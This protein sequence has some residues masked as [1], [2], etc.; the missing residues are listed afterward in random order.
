MR[1]KNMLPL[2][3][4]SFLF[5]AKADVVIRYRVESSKMDRRLQVQKDS[6][7]VIERHDT[8]TPQDNF[9]VVWDL[10]REKAYLASFATK[11]AI[12]LTVPTPSWE[13][14]RL[15]GSK[16]EIKVGKKTQSCLEAR[17]TSS[18][19][20]SCYADFRTALAPLV[21]PARWT[22]FVDVLDKRLPNSYLEKPHYILYL[23]R[24]APEGNMIITEIDTV[25][26]DPI[27][28]SEFNILP[29]QCEA[30]ECVGKLLA[31]KKK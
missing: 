26:K 17:T 2:L 7:F 31:V 30:K 20:I 9:P 10:K 21:E 16:R 22:K 3:A 29:G 11:T 19:I 15:T 23:E 25:K 5:A 4:C 8:P 27:Q 1:M 28:W 12:A 6:I 18:D 14:Q 13:R 24:K